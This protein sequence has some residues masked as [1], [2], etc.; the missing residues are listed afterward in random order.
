M[1]RRKI[2][3]G[4]VFKIL[5]QCATAGKRC[6]ENSTEGVGHGIIPALARAGRIRVE[7]S[8]QNYRTVTIM[9]GP[10]AGKSTA[11][12]PTGAAVYRIL[13]GEGDRRI[14]KPVDPRRPAPPMTLP[15]F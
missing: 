11:P 10:H 14:A 13:D 15:R 12:N 9:V 6:P 1:N 2:S 3:P 5:E 7:I 4:D 8:G